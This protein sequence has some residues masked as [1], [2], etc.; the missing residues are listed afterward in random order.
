MENLPNREDAKDYQKLENK[1]SFVSQK[2]FHKIHK[3]KELLTHN[4]PA[5]FGMCI[6]V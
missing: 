3:I 5:Y 2:I 4:K 6:L 1:T